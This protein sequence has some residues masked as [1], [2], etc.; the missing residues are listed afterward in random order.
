MKWY[1]KVLTQYAT[2]TGRA[3]RKEYWMFCLC[4][5]LIC[6]GAGFVFALLGLSHSLNILINIYSLAVAIPSIAV[7]IRRMHDTGHSGW[8]LLIPIY[9]LYLLA[10]KGSEG[11]NK[12]GPDPK[13]PVTPNNRHQ[14]VA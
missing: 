11:D 12:F 3:R 6:F 2:F 9:S 7:A 13:N 5:F 1:I 10:I 8:F 14:N 4:H